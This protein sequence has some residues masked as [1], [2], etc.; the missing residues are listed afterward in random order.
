V[1]LLPPTHQAGGGI[2]SSAHWHF[3]L[4]CPLV[5]AV[6]PHRTVLVYPLRRLHISQLGDRTPT[7]PL[8]PQFAFCS[9][10]VY[11]PPA[12]AFAGFGGV[13]PAVA[14]GGTSNV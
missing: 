7:A 2:P 3:H 4:L 8:P 9:L 1:T 14:A 10:A 11:F 13:Y 12:A 5:V 6:L